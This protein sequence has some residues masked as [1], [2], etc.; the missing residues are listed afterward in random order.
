MRANYALREPLPQLDRAARLS[1]S[2]HVGWPRVAGRHAQ[3][4][5]AP[6]RI[7]PDTAQIKNS[8]SDLFNPRNISKFLEF[9]ENYRNA[10]KLETKFHWTPLGQLFTVGLTK[11]IF[12]QQFI[13]QNYKNSNTKIN[14]YK[15]LYMQIL[16]I[17][18]C[19]FISYSV[20]HA[21]IHN[22]LLLGV[23]PII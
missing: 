10:Q 5:V 9:I 22:Y 17:F 20:V 21:K 1:P 2:Q 18:A 15:Y 4:A 11:S 7:G 3:W 13:V 16:W 6:G 14:A 8:F 23:I 19:V 12:V